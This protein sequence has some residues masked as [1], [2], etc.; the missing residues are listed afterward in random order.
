MEIFLVDE[1][2]NKIQATVKKHLINRFKENIIEDNYRVAEHEFKLV[3]LNRTTVIPVPDDAIPKTCFSF[4]P[5]DEL[6]KMTTDYVYL[7]DVIGLLTSVGE[8]KEYV[9][10]GKVMKMIVLELSSKELAIRCA[11][12]GEYVDEVHR[13]LGS[14][15]MEQP[16]VVIQFAK[17]KFFRAGCFVGQV[18]IQNVMH[19]TRLFFNPD[20]AEV[21]DFKN[22]MVD[23]GINGTQPLFIANDGKGISLE[24]DFMWL[25]RRCTIKELHDNNEEGSFVVFGIVRSIVDE[26]PWWY[27]ACV[28]GKSIQPQGGAYYYDFC[29]HYVINVT[30]R[31]RIKIAVEND[32]GHGVFVLFDFEAAYLLKKSCADLF[33]EVQKDASVVCGDSYPVMFQQ[34]LGKKL[35]LKIDTKSV[36]TDKYFGTFRVRRVCDDAAIISMFELPNYNAD[37]ECTPLKDGYLGKIP[38]SDHEYIVGKKNPCEVLDESITFDGN[39][40]NMK[41]NCK[42]LIDFLGEKGAEVPGLDDISSEVDIV[43]ERENC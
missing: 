18:G 12:F 33:E 19:A 21:V 37:D 24:D 32:N 7:V 28:Y 11:L 38:S 26:G 22:S 9:K 39:C 1:D 6:L 3:F 16:V 5:F 43:K 36:G 4:Y 14:S 41:T 17:V 2:S 25:T 27:S 20:L 8:E 31:Y 42:P 15:Y 10:D 30:L 34:L 13:F 23:Q 29:Q 35:V 40:S